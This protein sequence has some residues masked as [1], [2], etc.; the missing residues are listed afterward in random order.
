MSIRSGEAGVDQI[1]ERFQLTVSHPEGERSNPTPK[2][3]CSK[4]NKKSKSFCSNFYSKFE[5]FLIHSRFAGIPFAF[6]YGG[7]MYYLITYL[8]LSDAGT[9]PLNKSLNVSESVSRWIF[10]YQTSS[11]SFMKSYDYLID[12]RFLANWIFDLF[13]SYLVLNLRK[14]N[15]ISTFKMLNRLTIPRI[16]HQPMKLWREMNGKSNFLI[17]A[18]IISSYQ[19]FVSSIEN[20]EKAMWVF[21]CLG[22]S[23]WF[24]RSEIIFQTDNN[25]FTKDPW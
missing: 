2:R 15:V 8:V 23:G 17:L 19:R 18:I 7:Y 13:Y 21:N 10:F 5:H 4:S 6:L 14:L 11:K 22:R 12:K 25:F 9:L 3:A 16:L 24:G 20:I 1:R